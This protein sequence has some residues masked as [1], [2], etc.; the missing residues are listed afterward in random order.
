[1]ATSG[2]LSPEQLENNFNE[3]K[4]ETWINCAAPSESGLF[5]HDESFP[6]GYV[7]RNRNLEYHRQLDRR[8]GK[9]RTPCR[10]QSQRDEQLGG[11][12]GGGGTSSSAGENLT[13]GMD[14]GGRES[15][16]AEP[17]NAVPPVMGCRPQTA[18]EG[19]PGV[20]SL[21]ATALTRF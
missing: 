1:M 16:Q 10:N 7:I 8:R 12:I 19:L 20:K 14:I 11:E 21:K 15:S 18:L 6:R 2:N 17:Q 13:D 9:R 5:F 4:S 3:F